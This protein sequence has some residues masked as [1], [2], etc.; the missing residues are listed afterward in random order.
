MASDIALVA[1]PQADAKEPLLKMLAG[2]GYLAFWAPTP[3]ELEQE[4]ERSLVVTAASLLVVV[5]VLLA[6]SC[7]HT[8]ERCARQRGM[9]RTSRP[10][11]VLVY[12]RGALTTITR[13]A[14]V[15]CDTVV[16]VERPLSIT[17]LRAAA[18][19][20]KISARRFDASVTR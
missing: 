19:E 4:L 10:A 16:I 8:F 7:S 3:T 6:K 2:V 5:D 14:L 17:E 11:V 15:G 1:E 9:L 13:P 18:L 20:S 12:E